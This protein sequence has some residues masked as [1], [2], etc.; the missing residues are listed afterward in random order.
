[1]QHAG[2]SGTTEIQQTRKGSP[3]DRRRRSSQAFLLRIALLM[4]S[5]A[6]IAYTAWL[7][8]WAKPRHSLKVETVQPLA[9]GR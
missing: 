9:P 5:I 3:N 8:P 1:M 7:A 2:K 6:G 4:L